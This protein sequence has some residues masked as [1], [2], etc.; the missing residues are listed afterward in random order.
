MTT[1]FDII[2]EQANSAIL[3]RD[4]QFAEKILLSQLKKIDDSDEEHKIILKMNLAN[5]Y[6]R[7]NNLDKSLDIYKELNA[8]KPNDVNI[9]NGLGVV[10]RKLCLFDK[11]I[12]ALKEAKGLNEKKETTLYNL[13]NTYKQTGD[14][15]N[16]INCFWK[17][18]KLILTML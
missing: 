7:S 5:L 8:I 1:D 6:L 18:W 13:G 2:I 11:S 3:S 12:E 16:S 10:Y 14:Y 17:F 4:Y 15:Q 9:L